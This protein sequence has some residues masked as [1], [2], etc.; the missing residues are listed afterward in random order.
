M[1]SIKNVRRRK[2]KKKM[3][4]I[5]QCLHVMGENEVLQIDFAGDE[6]AVKEVEPVNLR[7]ALQQIQPGETLIVRFGNEES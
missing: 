4:G 6:V 1:R 5:R 2:G 3:N 7:D